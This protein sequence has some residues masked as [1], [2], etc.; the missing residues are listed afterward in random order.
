VLE[1][2]TSVHLNLQQTPAPAP[3]AR[4]VWSM[5]LNNG[6]HGIC[7]MLP[8]TFFVARVGNCSNSAWFVAYHNEIR[9]C[10]I[11][12][13]DDAKRAAAE[14]ALAEIAGDVQLIM[15]TQA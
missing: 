11:A 3:T 6:R 7:T 12:S 13:E 10:G 2:V 1:G 5:P 8:H 14:I 4:L 9:C 15:E